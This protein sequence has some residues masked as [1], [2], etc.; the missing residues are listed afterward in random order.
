MRFIESLRV[1]WTALLSNRLRALLTMLGIVIGVAAVITL[2]S[3]GQ[4]F[5]TFLNAQFQSIGSN[6]IFVIPAVPSGPN[7]K[8]I[9]SKPLTYPDALA[10]AN[11][12]NVQGLDGVAPVYNVTARVVF[13]NN[14]PAQQI[15][16]T[17]TAFLNVRDW[18]VKEGHF[19]EDTD[20]TTA[21]RVAVLG[22]D[23]VKKLFEDGEDPI[24]QDI[25]INNIPFRVIGVLTAKGGGSNFGSLDETVVVPISTAQT[26]LGN[27]NAR[28]TT[29]EYRVSAIYIKSASDDNMQGIKSQIEALMRD[30]HKVNFK[31]DEDFTVITQE[32]ILSI[33]GNIT[34]LVTV[35]LG[36]I[37][38]I[39]LFVGGIGVMNI[40][41]VSVTERTREIGL[42][43]AVGALYS[44]LMMQFLI[45]SV[46]LSVGGGMI[47]V[48]IGAG[49]SY[50]A[51]QL[52]PDLHATVTLGAVLLATGVSTAIGVFFGLYPASRAASLDPIE[53]L[54]YE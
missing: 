39:S 20:V 32:Q 25:R 17:T 1:A 45:E 33:V 40:M 53:A 28:T 41:L 47:G 36:L 3:L 24:G 31:G 6:L 42:R 10:I 54:R 43:K 51:S 46:V 11:P 5:Q 8:T 7:S 44:D 29:G 38:G 15:T 27:A 35:F 48:L 2:I 50:L 14:N 22:V 18:S 23:T 52:I 19:F 21:A 30:R 34:G 4:S 37:A 13:G 16:G 12:L 49:F 26:R 9:K